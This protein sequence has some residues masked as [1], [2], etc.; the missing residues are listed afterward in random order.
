ME[1]LTFG[2]IVEYVWNHPNKDAVFALWTK[3]QL[4]IALKQASDTNCLALERDASG[5]ITG[6]VFGEKNPNTK[7]MWIKGAI[8]TAGRCKLHA[9]M[10]MFMRHYP[11]YRIAATRHG[12]LCIYDTEQLCR[13]LK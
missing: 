3:D 11:T 6:V 5:Y 12:K 8:V 9:F 1:P 7:T 13:L 10:R 4:I 2:D